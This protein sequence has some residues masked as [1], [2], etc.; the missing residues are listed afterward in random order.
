MLRGK[1][2]CL[3]AFVSLIS[4]VLP[5][6]VSSATTPITAPH[7]DGG[8][9]SGSPNV[10]EVTYPDPATSPWLGGGSPYAYPHIIVFV[11][12]PYVGG[13]Q[14]GP[15]PTPTASQVATPL[16]FCAA[17]LGAG[18]V[19]TSVSMNGASI[20][21]ASSRQPICSFYFPGAMS[22]GAAVVGGGEVVVVAGGKPDYLPS[23]QEALDFCTAYS[24]FQQQPDF[25]MPPLPATS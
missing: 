19:P 2:A 10:C 16:S 18:Y 11:F 8:F 25:P 22:Y 14:V 6:V 12:P 13:T 1:V 15:A 5:G 7:Q 17:L 3:L 20:T 23:I 21:G 24:A 4:A 9:P